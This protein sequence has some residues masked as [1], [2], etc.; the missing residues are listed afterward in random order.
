MTVG[1]YGLGRFGRYWAGLLSDR[2]DRVVGFSRTTKDNL[3]EG[4]VQVAEDEL[5][6]VDA[7]F[8]CVSISSFEEVLKGIAPRLKPG[9]TVFDTCSVKLYPAELMKSILPGGISAIAS[10]PMFGP[11]SGKESVKGLPMVMYPVSADPAVFSFWKDVFL[12]YG[13]DVIEMP[14]DEHD[15]QAAYTQGVTHFIGRVLQGLKLEKSAIGT[16]GY[17]KLLEIVEQTCN[18]PLQLF[19]DLQRYNPYTGEMRAAVLE[20]FQRTL[21]ML[22]PDKT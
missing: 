12:E 13:M 22:N 2:F 18:D 14:P 9:M 10:H 4:V 1:V 7:L 11:D 6:Q 15:H 20:S 8:L 21:E 5:L 3:P 19:Y 16:V 17:H